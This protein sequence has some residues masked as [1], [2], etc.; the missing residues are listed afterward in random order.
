MKHYQLIPHLAGLR[1][2]SETWVNSIKLANCHHARVYL[3][4]QLQ[5]EYRHQHGVQV[6]VAC[7][8]RNRLFYN[9]TSQI[10]PSSIRVVICFTEPQSVFSPR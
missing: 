6:S 9:H 5:G 4:V 10:R 2:R 7:P 1:G 8:E 3:V